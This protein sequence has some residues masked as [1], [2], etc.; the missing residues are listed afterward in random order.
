MNERQARLWLSSPRFE[1]LLDRCNGD[2]KMA[3]ALHEWHASLSTASFSLIHHFEVLLRNAVDGVLG[4]AQPEIPITDTWLLDFDVLRPAS[5]T[6]SYGDIS[7]GWPS[8]WASRWFA[9]T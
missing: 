1:R 3:I 9:R 5:L 7:S 6:K 2:Q 8:R 4:R